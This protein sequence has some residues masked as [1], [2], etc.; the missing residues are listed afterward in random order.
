[1]KKN[2]C[3]TP[4]A[5]RPHASLALRVDEEVVNGV[6]VGILRRE[7]PLYV[8]WT[9]PYQPLS[10]IR[11]FILASGTST[12]LMTAVAGGP[13]FPI[14]VIRRSVWLPDRPCSTYIQL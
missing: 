14:W 5:G 12:D 11:S 8:H 7:P 2:T 4:C 10:I 3:I 13:L 9:K 6:T 1:M